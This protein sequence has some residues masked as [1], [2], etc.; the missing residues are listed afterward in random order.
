MDPVLHGNGS[1]FM[2]REEGDSSLHTLPRKT[3]DRW[4]P[5]YV[6]KVKKNEFIYSQQAARLGRASLPHS[7]IL[8]P[9]Y[10]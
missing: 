8:G 2:E 5:H 1:S 10:S 4:D 7:L 6:L 9:T 3:R